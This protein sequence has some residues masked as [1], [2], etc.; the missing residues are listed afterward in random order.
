MINV[1]ELDSK[2]KKTA[3]EAELIT[4]ANPR[5]LSEKYDVHYSTVMTY[6]TALREAGTEDVKVL[7][8]ADLGLVK[9]VAE[10]IKQ[11]AVDA[12]ILPSNRADAKIEAIIKGTNGLKSLTDEFQTTITKLLHQANSYI[13]DDMKLS[14][15]RQVATTVGELHEKTF[16]KGGTQVNVQQNNGGSGFSSGMV[17]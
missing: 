10:E 7:N 11:R 15:F 4:G 5:K 13:N 2:S 16:S 1:K 17:N 6:R 8:D 3:I 12:E 9:A 14:E